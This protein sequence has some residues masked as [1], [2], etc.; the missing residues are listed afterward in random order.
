M[1]NELKELISELN[2]IVLYGIFDAPGHVAFPPILEGTAVIY[3]D[4]KLT[5]CQQ[6]TVL[7]HELGHI[8]KQREEKELYDATMSMKMKME[9][10]ANKFMI[11]YLFSNYIDVTGDDPHS[12]NYL[13][14]M[15]QND[16]PSR[17]ENIVR[18]VI[19]NYS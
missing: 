4:N 14:F 10:G 7:I 13:E 17:D 11:K 16:I 3:I 2:A 18:E 9:Y 6:K 5:E 8:A 15:R 12:V 19:L 1:N